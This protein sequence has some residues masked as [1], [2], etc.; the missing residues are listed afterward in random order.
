MKIG[1]MKGFVFLL[2]AVLAIGC[3]KENDIDTSDEQMQEVIENA[4]QVL[5]DVSVFFEIAD[6][7]SDMTLHLDEIRNMENVE[8][9]WQEDNS[10]AVKIKDGG[11][12]KW[13]FFPKTSVVS[14]KY[15]PDNVSVYNKSKTT[16]IDICETKT[17]CVAVTVP[18]DESRLNDF[19]FERLNIICDALEENG[20]S[21]RRVIGDSVTPNFIFEEIPNYGVNILITHGD[22]DNSQKHWI[23]TG[24]ELDKTLLTER[25]RDWMS[26][27]DWVSNR[28]QLW[29]IDEVRNGDTVY[30]VYL[31]VSESLIDERMTH[32]FPDNSLFFAWACST[33]KSKSSY[34]GSKNDSFYRILKNK[35]L[36]C[37]FGY[38]NTVKTYRALSDLTN[39]MSYMLNY[40]FTAKEAYKHTGAGN[41]NE[42]PRFFVCPDSSNVAL[43]G[44]REFVFSVSETKKV[45]FS[46]GNLA[47]G[48]R[49]FVAHQWESGG[50]FGWG[51]GNNPNNTSVDEDDYTVFNDWGNHIAGGWRTLT[52]DEW[53]YL[54]SSRKSGSDFRASGTVNGVHGLII[55]PDNWILP[56][57]CTF[58]SGHVNG[59]TTN[60]YSMAQWV[61]MEQSGAI[62]LPVGGVRWGTNIGDNL[63]GPDH[64]EGVWGYYWSSSPVTPQDG[65]SLTA[66]HIYFRAT[67]VI[68]YSS[69][70]RAQ[71]MSVR[72]VKDMN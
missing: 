12:I 51:T 47:Q 33:L 32:R 18:F 31:A 10:I 15:T 2:L 68:Y 40:G 36:D 45:K 60:V 21:V 53:V 1:F 5:T 9:A 41:Y 14:E 56:S 59:W 25:I 48:G 43:T 22:F 46:S 69:C 4:Q 67:G 6:S 13:C 62:F 55:L 70:L 37:Y 35:G 39:I 26:Y 66:C 42:P 27:S 19:V 34:I 57:T 29:C 7:I 64:I 44:N 17:A 72:L 63:S 28:M 3:H 52:R 30:P 49:G 16:G 23:M 58:T 8:D 61:L 71:G 50:L 54:L 24:K 38:N 20:Y 11:I 65:S